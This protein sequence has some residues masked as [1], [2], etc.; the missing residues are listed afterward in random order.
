MSSFAQLQLQFSEKNGKTY[1]IADQLQQYIDFPIK[2][3]YIIQG[4]PTDTGQ[5]C[6]KE[7][8]EFFVMV[9]GSCTAVID[10]GNGKEDILLQGPVG[11][12]YVPNYVWHGFKNFSEDAIILAVSSTVYK[13]DRSDYIEDYDAYL[14]VRDEKL[15]QHSV[16]S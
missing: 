14:K 6:H 1:S 5:H 10:R 3:F 4:A 13:A 2:R 9:K 11:S 8:K 15:N 12:I 7:E 16:T